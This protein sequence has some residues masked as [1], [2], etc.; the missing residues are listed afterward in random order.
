MIPMAAT[1]RPR[2][3]RSPRAWHELCVNG[4]R[5][6]GYLMAAQKSSARLTL[7][8]VVVHSAAHESNL[9]RSGHVDASWMSV[10]GTS[11]PGLGGVLRRAA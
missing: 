2:S 9:A 10:V 1:Q 5:P 8:S 11:S 3:D 4:L 7:D 6:Q